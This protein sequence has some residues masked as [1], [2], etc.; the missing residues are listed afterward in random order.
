ML[1]NSAYGPSPRFRRSGSMLT[2]TLMAVGA[3]LATGLLLGLLQ[4]DV[5]RLWHFPAR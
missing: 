1:E 4:P 2:H 3:A 5:R